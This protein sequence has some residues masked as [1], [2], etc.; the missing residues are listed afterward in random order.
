MYHSHFHYFHLVDDSHNVLR[1]FSVMH[2]LFLLPYN[3]MLINFLFFV[4][5]CILGT[6]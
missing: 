5:S 2:L 4:F 6:N 3:I 1:T